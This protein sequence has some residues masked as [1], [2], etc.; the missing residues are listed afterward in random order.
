MPQS[1][2]QVLHAD[3]YDAPA[4]APTRVILPAP[5]VGTPAYENN[6]GEFETRLFLYQHLRDLGVAA[7]AAAGWDG[8]R[9][10]HVN[11]PQGDGIAWVVVFDTPFDAGEFF[12]A[13][14]QTITRRSRYARP[15]E[16]HATD[17]SYAGGGRT[18]RVQAIEVQ[19][20]PA[21]V[22]VDMP[23]GVST[24]VLDLRQVRLEELP[25]APGAER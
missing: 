25:A 18:R 3:A 12:D 4:D 8:D 2:E 9:Y 24:D 14:D 20:R 15:S 13:V 10:L 17:R 22:Y 21:V 11:T 5:R 1:T 7:R 16:Q 6:L 19:G 23:T